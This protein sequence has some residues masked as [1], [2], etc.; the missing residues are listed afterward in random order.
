M[1]PISLIVSLE[2][3]KVLQSL[4]IEFD[5]NMRYEP[6]KISCKVLNTMIHEELGKIEYIFAD[7]TGTLTSNNME[8]K[9]CS[10]NMVEFSIENLLKICESKEK[11]DECLNLN[12][13]TSKRQIFFDFWLALIL[14]HDVLVDVEKDKKKN[15]QVCYFLLLVKTSKNR[16]LLQMK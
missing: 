1:I 6:F 9:R 3:I 12:F 8:F 16:A 5:A 13:E 11:L 7:K 2:V 10:I 4:M 14:C 15:F